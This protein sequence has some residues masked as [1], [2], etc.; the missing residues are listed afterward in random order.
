M[1]IEA[2][3][4]DLDELVQVHAT[5]GDIKPLVDACIDLELEQ[6]S[7]DKPLEPKDYEIFLVALLI[8]NNLTGAKFLWKRMPGELK[9]GNESL[10]AL[11]DIGKALFTNSVAKAH[12]S[13]QHA[14]QPRTKMLVD[15]LS[16]QIRDTEIDLLCRSYSSVRASDAATRLGM[17]EAATVAYCQKLGWAFDS[18]KNLLRPKKLA[19]GQIRHTD[20][21]QLTQLSQYVTFLE[22]KST[23]KNIEAQLKASAKESETPTVSS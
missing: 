9:K 8:Q 10:Q 12:K 5:G 14:F 4:M 20:L 22:Q 23:T 16:T 21:K 13:L 15:R 17:D 18:A 7:L 1:K 6:A 11:W 2:E 3:K 19:S